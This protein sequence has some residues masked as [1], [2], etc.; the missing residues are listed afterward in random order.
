MKKIR[1]LEAIRQ[2]K[3]GGGETHVLD[4]TAHLDKNKFE[5]IVLSFTGGEMIEELNNRHIQNRII[6]TEKAFNFTIWKKVK[7]LLI[8]EEIDMVH[9]HGTRALSNVFWAAKKLGLPL[10]YTI[11]GWSFHLD[12]PFPVRK[13]RELSEKFLTNQTHTNICVSKSNQHDGIE[14][15]NMKNSKVIYNAI[16]LQKF[17]PDRKLNN[18][19]KEFGIPDGHV[20]F[21][22]IVRFTPQKDPVTLLKAF[23]EVLNEFDQVT[24]LAVG[25]GELKKQSIELCHQLKMEEHVKFIPFRTDIPDILNT[26]DIYCLPSLWE[27]FPI[28][29]LEAMAMKKPVIASAVDGTRELIE[30]QETGIL[31][32]HSNFGTLAKAMVSL[33]KT[34]QHARQIGQNAFNY[35]TQH[36]GIEQLAE[37]VAQTYFEA[38][39]YADGPLP[40]LHPVTG[41]SQT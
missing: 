4:L 17:N 12:Q 5:P 22:Y 33:L 21:G 40:N 23:K 34:P 38:Y 16:D 15:F 37:N 26:I 19:R 11:H 30:D 25:D 32:P 14:R 28:G 41:F 7:Q 27:G 31:V 35:V 9:A 1:V 13:A 18:Y 39:R 10:I 24:L 3:I 6:D 20:V 8:E 29:I 2:G 36:F